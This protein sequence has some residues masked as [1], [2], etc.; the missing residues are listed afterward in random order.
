M[1]IKWVEEKSKNVGIETSSKRNTV[2]AICQSNYI[3]TIK[4]NKQRLWCAVSLI[5]YHRHNFQI[6]LHTTAN[7]SP[8]AIEKE[9]NGTSTDAYANQF[10]IFVH[11]YE[12]FNL[13]SFIMRL[14]FLFGWFSNRKHS[15]S[16][17]KETLFM[18]HIV[19]CMQIIMD[20]AIRWHFDTRLFHSNSSKAL[21]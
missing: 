6:S 14:Y 15:L 7:V 18:H 4:K 3:K 21:M 1:T 13:L 8:I 2:P 11:Q 12:Y 16:M 17:S 9:L 20:D 5:S 19:Y 10:G